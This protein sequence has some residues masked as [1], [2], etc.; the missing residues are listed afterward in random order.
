[1]KIKLKTKYI[2]FEVKKNI[3]RYQTKW[4][5]KN[6]N[7]D[8]VDIQQLSQIPKRTCDDSYNW[9]GISKW[10]R[11][12]LHFSSSKTYHI[13]Y[14]ECLPPEEAYY[15]CYQCTSGFIDSKTLINFW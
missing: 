9:I 5:L 7:I 1:M 11:I 10:F 4:W 3:F 12:Q 13:V 14:C 2:P 15:A 8:L 6:D